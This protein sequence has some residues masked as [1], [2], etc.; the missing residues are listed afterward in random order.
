M[1]TGICRQHYSLNFFLPVLQSLGSG[2]DG[3]AHTYELGRAKHRWLHPPF[4]TPH[5]FV[6]ELQ[7]KNR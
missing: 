5:G 2:N 1:E 6:P 4:S 3:Q 7:N